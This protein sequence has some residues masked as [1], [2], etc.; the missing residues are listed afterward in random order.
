[1][2]QLV[3][4]LVEKVTNEPI[5]EL[6]LQGIKP[7]GL[8][9]LFPL[10]AGLVQLQVLAELLEKLEDILRCLELHGSL[11]EWPD[12]L[13]V[14]LDMVSLVSHK[15]ESFCVFFK[16]LASLKEHYESLESVLLNLEFLLKQELHG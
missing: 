12:H 13:V 2:R 10:F 4:L 8:R 15:Q 11:E 16:A 7:D 6:F 1:M 14:H 5:I 9:L 3:C